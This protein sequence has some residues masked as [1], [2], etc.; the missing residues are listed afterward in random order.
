VEGVHFSNDI[1]ALDSGYPTD[2]SRHFPSHCPTQP[3][4]VP[5]RDQPQAGRVRP[6]P[7]LTHERLLEA[8][9]AAY[10]AAARELFAEFAPPFEGAPPS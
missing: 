1:S 3:V 4:V 9:S 7:P 8:A 2:T 5:P 10:Q 6:A